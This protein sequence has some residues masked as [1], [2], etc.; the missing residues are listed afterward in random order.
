MAGIYIYEVADT[1]VSSS[2][3]LGQS[4]SFYFP[5]FAKKLKECIL[6]IITIATMGVSPLQ[7]SHFLVFVL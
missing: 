5:L 2:Y 4:L 1:F 7:F 3:F 6:L